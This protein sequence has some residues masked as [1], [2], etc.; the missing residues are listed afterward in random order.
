MFNDNKPYKVRVEFDPTPIR[1]IAVQCPI[2]E[3][4]FYGYDIT[5]DELTYDYQIGFAH[6]RCPLC[7]KYFGYGTDYNNEQ[8]EES[9]HPEVYRDCLH[10]QVKWE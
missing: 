3:K 4:W 5:D 8:I 1:H 2:C 10:K 9:S 6:Y 7:E